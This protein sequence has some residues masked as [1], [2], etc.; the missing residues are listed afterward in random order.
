[1]SKS[2]EDNEVSPQSWIFETGSKIT[3]DIRNV[4]GGKGYQLAELAALRYPV[5]YFLVIKTSALNHFWMNNPDCLNQCNNL[6]AQAKVDDP[7]EL[8]QLSSKIQ[9]AVTG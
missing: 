2:N 4:L 6:L 8:E 5:P 9:V 1:M 3:D 7:Y